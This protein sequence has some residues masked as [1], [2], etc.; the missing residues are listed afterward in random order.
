MRPHETLVIVLKYY[1][2]SVEDETLILKRIYL[3]FDTPVTVLLIMRTFQHYLVSQKK[4][5]GKKKPVVMA[6]WQVV[7]NPKSIVAQSIWCAV[8]GWAGRLSNRLTD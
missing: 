8:G 7:R 4:I 3:I 6:A 1:T 2:K 5:A